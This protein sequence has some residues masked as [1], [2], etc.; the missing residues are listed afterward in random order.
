MQIG[1]S[2]Y[3]VSAYDTDDVVLGTDSGV[4]LAIYPGQE[5]GIAG[6]LFVNDETVEVD[7]I[8]VQFRSGQPE[9][10]DGAFEFTVGDI[11]YM[12][13]DFF[14][15]ASSIVSN[16]FDQDFSDIV[17]YAVAYNEA[18]EIIGGGFTF[19][20]FI[21]AQGQAAADILITTTGEPAR[22]DMYPM[23]SFLSVSE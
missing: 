22:V 11:N 12:P 15:S 1:G 13:D 19:L 23:L 2:E 7:R 3:Q 18:E 5:V 17:V 14:P 8:E 16:P 4:I 10:A 21:P 9:N 20:E 6:S